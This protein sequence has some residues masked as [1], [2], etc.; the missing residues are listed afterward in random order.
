MALTP[1]TTGMTTIPKPEDP[2][3]NQDA[4]KELTGLL[5]KDNPLMLQARTQGLQT[6]ASRGLLSS[7]MAAGAS[8]AAMVDRAAPLAQQNAA[9]NAAQN[10][11][12]Q[13]YTQSSANQATDIAAQSARQTQQE[14]AQ[15][16]LQQT[17]VAA[18][19]ARQAA[20]IAARTDLQTADAA[21]QQTLQATDLAA[22]ADRQQA[23]IASDA[24]TRQ[25]DRG[26]QTQLATWNLDAAEQSNAATMLN[27]AQAN[28][29]AQY[30][31]I[32]SNTNM[33]AQQ[34]E[35][36]VALARSE[37]SRR[38]AVTEAFFGI[39]IEWATEAAPVPAVG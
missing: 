1:T 34:R 10:L 17:D 36:Q 20:D 7:S 28:Y 18:Q 31:G 27:S 25:L 9:Q 12:Y 39:N 13:G 6:A 32:M 29:S 11:S 2:K 8:T 16:A 38:I 26:L 24:A 5:S 23:Q 37:L 35:D 3:L 22:S 30:Q 19:S 33:N 15:T 14:A 4:G 21:Q